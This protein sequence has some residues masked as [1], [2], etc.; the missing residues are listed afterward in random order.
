[1]R[2]RLL[3]EGSNHRQM[4]LEKTANLDDG[5]RHSSKTKRLDLT[6]QLHG[7][8]SLSMYD[9]GVLPARIVNLNKT[10]CQDPPQGSEIV[11]PYRD[12]RSLY[13]FMKL[14]GI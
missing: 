1:M 7:L 8:I 13:S 4:C 12:S 10:S 6:F 3:D 9:L 11:Q 2:K 5:T 14:L